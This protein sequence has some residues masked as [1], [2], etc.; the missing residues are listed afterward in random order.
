MIQRLPR[1]LLL[2]IFA[3]LAR[4]VGTLRAAALTCHTVLPVAHEY[5]FAVI[6]CRALAQDDMVRFFPLVIQLRILPAEARAL[7]QGG[8]MPRLH[9]NRFPKLNSITFLSPP[10]AAD[11]SLVGPGC[12]EVLSRLASANITTLTLS[13][14][15]FLNLKHVQSF[16]CA[17]PFLSF[18]SIRRIT[19]I[20]PVARRGDSL[21]LLNGVPDAGRMPSSP[22]LSHLCFEPEVVSV[23]TSEVVTWL[24]NGPSYKTLKSLIIPPASISPQAILRHFG[25]SVIHLALPLRTLESE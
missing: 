25:P 2:L 18:L 19:Y 12:F 14:S 20:T 21:L 6:G 13:S 3:Y 8:F 1:E 11:L 9:P 4:D 16:I 17:L 7:R 24:G 15:M 23:A 22:A 5:L 10:G